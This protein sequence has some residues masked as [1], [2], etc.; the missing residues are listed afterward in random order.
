MNFEKEIAALDLK[1]W[2]KICSLTRSVSEV[3]GKKSACS[4]H[5]DKLRNIRRF[6]CLC[7]IFFCADSRCSNPMYVLLTDIVDSHG[8]SNELIEV[9]NR[10]GAIASLD[11]RNRAILPVIKKAQE[12]GIL[13]PSAFTICF[14]DNLDYLSSNAT[15]YCGDQHRSWHGTSVQAVRPQPTRLVQAMGERN[16]PTQMEIEEPG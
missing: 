2:Q 9:L 12:S 3:S 16:T 7:V 5:H 6:Y 14:F 8:G 4:S 13:S 11:T 1:L 15:V 10:I